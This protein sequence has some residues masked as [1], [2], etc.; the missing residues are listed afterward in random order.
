MGFLLEG[1][2]LVEG[3]GGAMGVMERDSRETLRRESGLGRS[4]GGDFFSGSGSVEE[5]AMP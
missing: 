5:R 4:G 2:L 3:G 1:L